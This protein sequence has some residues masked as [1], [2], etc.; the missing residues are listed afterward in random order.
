ME[1]LWLRHLALSCPALFAACADPATSATDG[2]E[3]PS[4][5]SSSTSNLDSTGPDTS[6][7][8]S[9][10][11][12]ASSSADGSSPSS[13]A[14]ESTL[15]S[16]GDDEVF[17]V[18]DVPELIGPTLV[19]NDVDAEGGPVTI[20]AFDAESEAGAMVYIG[21][22]GEVWYAP[23]AGFWGTDRFGYTATDGTSEAA[24]TVTVY[25]APVRIDLSDVADGVGGFAFHSTGADYFDVTGVGDVN[26]DGRDD[27]LVMALID[28]NVPAR[29]RVVFGKPDGELVDLDEVD[30]D[31][32]FDI[33][34]EGPV[35][36]L[37]AISAAGDVDGDGLADVIVGDGGQDTTEASTAG[38]S[39]VVFGKADDAAV[40]LAD[41]SDGQG[42][43]AIDG[44][45]LNQRT[46][47]SVAAAGDLDGD[48][49]DDVVVRGGRIDVGFEDIPG[50]LAYVVFGKADGD[51][52]E[53]GDVALGIGGFTVHDGSGAVESATVEAA[54]DV[55]GDD[56][57][58]FMVNMNPSGELLDAPRHAYVVFGKSDTETVEAIDLESDDGG[59][60]IVAGSGSSPLAL[61]G[62]GDVNADGFAD[63]IVGDLETGRTHVIFGEADH[64]SV[65][66]SGLGDGG[67]AIEPE[68]GFNRTAWSVANAGDVNRD[69]Y[70][71][72]LVDNWDTSDDGS[73]VYVVFGGA[74]IDGVELAD[75]A[76]GIGG[77]VI[78]DTFLGTG[79][80][81]AAGGDLD[82]DGTA[83]LL[84]GNL[85]DIG[86]LDN[87][88]YAYAV[89]GVPT[90]P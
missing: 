36:R 34:A 30:D 49:F 39:Y 62:G 31:G 54:G 19:A 23:P 67:F 57:E 72:V 1:N 63:V 43:F 88:E 41:V 5:A 40:D 33:I 20:S 38:R 79:G 74:M 15:P 69:G 11:S 9:T 71:D 89:F 45:G 82:G 55:D 51:R 8:P 35:T 58:D 50:Q 7:M 27:A 78:D 12:D 64:A 87:T 42:G 80:E 4:E 28:D 53:L 77:Y 52:V 13:G 24:A 2:S 25:V 60:E 85:G 84:I 17:V 48:G 16:V 32:G 75:V 29:T 37:L 26:G 70:D 44:E 18:Q 90:G 10:E 59:F 81:I 73:R 6:G 76:L 83:D 47:S 14:S 65:V 21:E 22:G 86:S 3:G 46:G 61:S 66:L 68:P 56:I